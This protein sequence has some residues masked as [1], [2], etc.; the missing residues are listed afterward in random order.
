MKKSIAL[1][2]SLAS[3]IVLLLVLLTAAARSGG[4]TIWLQC[5]ICGKT[6]WTDDALL[7]RG[8][9]GVDKEVIV[10]NAIAVTPTSSVN[11]SL[12]HLDNTNDVVDVQTS[13]SV[14]NQA[15][16]I[17]IVQ[18]DTLPAATI[19]NSAVI[20]GHSNATKHIC[21]QCYDRYTGPIFARIDA[22]WNEYWNNV[23]KDYPGVHLPVPPDT[24]RLIWK[25]SG[26]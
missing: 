16:G 14:T 3:L 10:D 6:L 15:K 22:N 26:K 8:S 2:L 7:D 12:L 11:T 5:D 9:Q 18:V 19:D 1:L 13:G 23:K 25:G 17:G 20:A 21:K 24:S 4:R